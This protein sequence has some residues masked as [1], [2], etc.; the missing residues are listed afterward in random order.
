MPLLSKSFSGGFCSLAYLDM[1]LVGQNA[2]HN[3]VFL[4]MSVIFLTAGFEIYEGGP[5]LM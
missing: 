2:V 5:F 1:L 4:N 3:C